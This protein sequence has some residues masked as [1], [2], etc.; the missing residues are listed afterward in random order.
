M[1]NLLHGDC[2]ELMKN[3]PDNSIDMVL[4]SPPYDNLR[5]YNNSSEWNFEIFKGIAKELRRI[6]SRGGVIVWIVNDATIKGS[7]TGSSFKQ[8]LYFK[9]MGL[10]LHDTMIWEK[11]SEPFMSKNRYRGKFEYMFVFSN[12]KPQAANL[13]RDRENKHRTS[14]GNTERLK[15]GKL[16]PRKDVKLGKFGYRFNIWNISEVK[17]N[18]TGHPA[19][20]PVGL[21]EDHIKTW[22]NLGQIVIDPFMGSGTTGIACKNLKRKFIGIEIDDTYFNI[23][24]ERIEKA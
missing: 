9:E 16:K 15:N 17:N 18:K 5:E 19:V 20:F 6:L 11:S 2:L 13:I 23:A 24:K 14:T 21:V 3:I 7:E 22:T 1:I 8:A 4:T 12:G 10:N